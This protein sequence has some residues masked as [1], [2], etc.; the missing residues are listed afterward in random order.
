VHDD[1]STGLPS[2]LSPET[3]D[4]TTPASTEVARSQL[5][6][7]DHST[8]ERVCP[9]L[10]AVADGDALGPP[11]EAPDPANRCVALHEPVPQ[12]LRQQDL[13]CLSSAHVN[14]PRYLR[15][16][17]GLVAPVE[18]VSATRAVTPATAAALA[19]FGLAFV[20]SVGF[21]VATGGL[22]L[23]AAVATATPGGAV[24]GEVETAAPSL[25]PTPDPTPE[26][27]P[28]ATPTASATPS[29][30]PIP[31]ASPTPSPTPEPTPKATRKPTSDRYALLKP[32]P[33]TPDCYVYVVR[34]GDNLFS[35]AKY[36]GVPLKT[37]EAM[38]PWTK[39][40]LVAGRDLRIPT[41][42]R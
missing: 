31:T 1:P 28:A 29:S 5:P 34:S 6:L 18:R 36:F 4:Q 35:I 25:V 20:V 3:D 8:T 42:T 22:A 40:G 11:V 24:L 37:V 23:T 32:C 33:G 38:N 41:P 15:G 7:G 26:P 17:V 10:R 39:S 12:S 30:S 14:C 9:F 13:V 16:S 19:L 21:V 27:T 2:S